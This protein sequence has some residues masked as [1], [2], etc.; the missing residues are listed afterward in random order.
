MSKGKIE[1]QV[2]IDDNG[3][4]KATARQ[5]DKTA[6]SIGNV[7]KSSRD[8]DRNIKGLAQ[9]SANGTKNFSKM[10]QG[11]TGGLVP[12]YA[13]FAA[14]IFALTAAFNFLKEAADLENLRKSQVAFAQSTGLALTTITNKLRESSKGMLGFKEASQAA[15]IGVAKGFSNA[16]LTEIT[17]GALK[18]S[19]ALGRGFQDTF[20]RLLRG[21]SKAEPELLD[22]LGITLRLETATKNYAESI[23]KSRDSLTAAERSQAVFVETMRQL[24]NTFGDVEARGNPFV[25]L[26]KTFED[27][28]QNLTKRFLPILEGVAN[29]INENAKAAAGAFTALAALI[30]VNISGL[31]KGIMDVFRVVGNQGK[32]VAKTIATPFQALGKIAGKGV[33]TGLRKVIDQLEGAEDALRKAAKETASKVKTDAQSMVAGGAGSA[34]LGKLAAGKEVTPQALGRLKKDLKRVQK[35]IEETGKTSSKAFA[36][37]SVDSIKKMR[38]SVDKMG[39]TSLTTGEKI[40]KIFAKGVVKAIDASR[41]AVELKRK[42]MDKLRSGATVAGN[43]FRKFGKIARAA[44]GFV[45]VILVLIK[46]VEKL[47]ET[48]ITVIDG[49]KKFLTTTLKMVQKVLNFLVSGLNS[50]LDNSIVRRI[51]GTKEGEKVVSDFTFADNIEETLNNLEKTVLDKLGTDRA[52]LEAVEQKT[53]DRRKQEAADLAEKNRVEDLVA[54]YTTLGA[55]IKQITKGVRAQND[56]FKKTKQIATGIGSLSIAGAIDKIALEDDP[57][58]RDTLLKAFK[59]QIESQDL[60]ALGSVFA[61]AVEDKDLEK[62]RELQ[63]SALGFNSS[64]LAVDEGIRTLGQNLT[65]GTSIEGAIEFTKALINNRDAAIAQAEA[66]GGVTD[67]KERLDSEFEKAGGADAFL[68]SLT[69]L[70]QETERLKT[71]A[72]NL[73]IQELE[74]QR[75]SEGNKK[76][77]LAEIKVLKEENAEKTKRNQLDI[78]NAMTNAI[79]FTPEQEQQ[80]EKKINQLKREVELMKEKL[81]LARE[82]ASD[83][84]QM[85]IKIGTSLEDNMTSAFDALVQG[86]KNFKQAFADMARA[87]LADISKMIARMLAIQILKSTLGNTGLGDFLGIEAKSGGVMTPKGKAPGY[88]TGGVA[89]GPMSGYPAILHGTEA[90]VP[91][92][93]G[94]S[95]P[96]EMSNG[97]QTQN[98]IVVNISSEGQTT[99]EG[100]TGPDMDRVGQAVAKAVQI[101]LQNQKRSGGMLNP[102]GAA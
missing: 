43:A 78:A 22:E 97:G 15:A 94:K 92:P 3:N 2:E 32:T 81:Q 5:A 4:L 20:D 29:V 40:K 70:A 73:A 57:K 38:K 89:R 82:Q 33:E 85:G 75:L 7:G 48:P 56:E 27:I 66:I 76:I 26:G 79:T 77:R 62:L 9:T 1:I 71:E 53:K 60:G 90:V 36:G 65:A 23:N 47:A 91:L 31:G 93:N 55:D 72:N 11:M 41:K 35:E 68:A 86:T 42:A 63:T 52:S 102:Y 14:Q 21:V 49:F 80:N 16:Q 37:V 50:L 84:I 17:E 34:T 58:V 98:N 44:F 99:T 25:Q 87:I 45:G 61:K 67:V 39:K 54:A 8:T 24:N 101:E 88:S 30:I 96:V 46:A 10:A 18:A 6:D 13:A 28:Q 12:A 19:T 100:S 51:L 59:E 95:I 69:G 83:I 74:A 64:L